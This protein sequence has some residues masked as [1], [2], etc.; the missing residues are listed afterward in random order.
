MII[1][2]VLSLCF[3]SDDISYIAN[4]MDMWWRRDAQMQLL[5]ANCHHHARYVSRKRGFHSS[6]LQRV[7]VAEGPV[8]SRLSYR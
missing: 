2:V 8:V 5:M 7:V 4:T 3:L 6:A 1:T